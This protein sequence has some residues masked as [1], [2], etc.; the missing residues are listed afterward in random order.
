MFAIIG[1]WRVDGALDSEQLDHIAANVRQQPGFV[2]AYWGQEVGDVEYAHAL[3]VLDDE[4][5]A[6]AMA[7]GVRAA[8]PSATLRVVRVLADA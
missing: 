8:I 1:K 5:S 4:A 2:R 6:Q 3:V 7:E